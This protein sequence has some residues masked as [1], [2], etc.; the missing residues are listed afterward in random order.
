MTRRV[1]DERGSISVQLD[2]DPQSFLKFKFPVI[3][4]LKRPLAIHN[5]DDMR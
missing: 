5:R 4:A 1:R 3:A 2:I